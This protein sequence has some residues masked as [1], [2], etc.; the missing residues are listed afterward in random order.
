MS[1]AVENL[2]ET[3]Q[4]KKSTK[5]MSMLPMTKSASETDTT[6]LKIFLQT[7]LSM[8]LLNHVVIAPDSCY[9]VISKEEASSL[10][11][12]NDIYDNILT[13]IK[14]LNKR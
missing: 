8:I 2:S 9:I 14:S 13:E 10:G 1:C 12:P 5:N 7:D 11:I 3:L 6:A 4:D